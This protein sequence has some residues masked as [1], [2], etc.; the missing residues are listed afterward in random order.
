MK[1]TILALL[2]PFLLQAETVVSGIISQ[3]EWWSRDKSPYIVTNDLVVGPDA[4]LVIEPGVQVF[5]E[6]PL[7]IPTGIAQES[8]ADTFST[9]IKI[10]GALRCV[11]K[12]DL[13]IVFKARYLSKGDEYTFWE[14][15]SINTSRT[16][17]VFVSFTQVRNASVGISVKQGTPLLRN[18]LL[19][20]NSIGIRVSDNSSPRIVN[21]LFTD[22]FLAALRVI[23]ANPEVY[24]SI[25]Y[26]NR[27][28]AI[29]SDHVSQL[30][31]EYNG[32]FDNGDRDFSNCIPELGI[33]AQSNKNGDSTD[34][35]NNIFLDPLFVGSVAEKLKKEQLLKELYESTIKEPSA[36]AVAHIT[37]VP[38]LSEDRKF[39]LSKFSPYIN[40]GNPSG[41]FREPDGSSPDLGI[42]GGPEFLQ[43]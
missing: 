41:K 43:F 27:N 19:Q 1:I 12:P 6:K 13:P 39:F 10:Y 21:S 23:K 11:G 25:F 30:T 38:L 3:N 15:I 37:E 20:T 22:N 28:I 32:L 26:Q 34:I 16:D 4:R 17:E 14:G 9:S 5:I 8:K 18:N 35:F 29:W 2:L 7:D 31:F 24:N 40:A 33:L 36:E 42:W